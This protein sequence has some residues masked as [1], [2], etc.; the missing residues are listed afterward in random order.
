MLVA[1]VLHEPSCQS[2]E[3]SD[4]KAAQSAG[5]YPVV[6]LS[7]SLSIFFFVLTIW[8]K[9][10]HFQPLTLVKSFASFRIQSHSFFSLSF[11]FSFPSPAPAPSPVPAPT[12]APSP[13]PVPAPQTV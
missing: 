7:K 6:Y 8:H 3:S 13:S 5:L 11:F 9:Q 4:I 12:P 2:K 10:F 1:P